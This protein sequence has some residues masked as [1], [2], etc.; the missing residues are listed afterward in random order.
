MGGAVKPLDKVLEEVESLQN[1]LVSHATSG[2]SYEGDYGTLRASPLAR[3]ECADQ[4]PRFVRTCRDLAQFWQFIKF[5]FPTYAERRNYL[6]GAFRPLLERVEK[7]GTAPA[8]RAV[9]EAIE[10]FDAGHLHAAW[11]KAVDRRQSDPDGA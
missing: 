6:W 8:D 3:V 9:S 2:T 10:R 1:I 5:K 11:A 4:I 7:G